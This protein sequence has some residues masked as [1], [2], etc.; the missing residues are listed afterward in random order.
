MRAKEFTE[1]C[2]TGY[3]QLGMKKKGKRKVPNC[4]P[5]NESVPAHA[6]KGE[7]WD[8]LPEWKKEWYR[9][10]KGGLCKHPQPYH[11]PNWMGV[12]ELFHPENASF[13]DW[14]KGNGVTYAH[15]DVDIDGK[16][17][18][19][20]IT[21][22]DMGAGIINI[23]FMVGGSFELTG[24]GGASKVFSTVIEAVR[25]FTIKNP[26]VKTITFTAEEKSRAR[27]Y[28]TIAKRV[29]HKLGWHVVPH[30]EVMTTPKYTT[31]RSYGAFSFAIEKGGAPVH[32]QAAQKPQHSKFL[33][34]YYVYSFELTELPAIKVI[35]K[36]GNV[37]EMFVRR[38]VPEYK[39][40][41]PMGIYA[42]KTPPPDRKVVDM[43]EVP[44]EP[45]KPAER[46][47]TPLET[48]LRNKLGA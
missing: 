11:K 35:A 7:E 22:A 32:R 17:V 46:V 5:V 43:G 16:N 39:N 19:I 25:E 28:D 37:A 12:N 4:V 33:I 41:D 31:L 10:W 27:M 14:E 26:R 47:P 1:A 48:A 42:S 8:R 13:L 30:E 3:K 20:D 36:D 40:A 29:S 21:F 2:W 34:T 15:G 6:P 9:K 24:K 23:E 38:N 45:P 44:P 18:A